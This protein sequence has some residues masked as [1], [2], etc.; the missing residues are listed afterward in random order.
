MTTMPA[1]ARATEALCTADTSYWHH[2]QTDDYPCTSCVEKAQTSVSA[3]LHDPEDPDALAKVLAAFDSIAWSNMH[4]ETK[5]IY[6]R[7][8]DAVRAAILGEAHEHRA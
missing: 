2:E 7:M 1:L 3:A 4:R 8:A 5:G 6:R